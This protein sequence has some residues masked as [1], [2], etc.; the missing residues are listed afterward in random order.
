MQNGSAHEPLR[1]TQEAVDAY[2]R[3]TGFTG[4]GK[5]MVEDGHWIIVPNREAL[6]CKRT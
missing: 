1:V 3:R 6:R 2:E 5:I 4:I